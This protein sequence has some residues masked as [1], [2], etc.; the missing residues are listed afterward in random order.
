MICI[1]CAVDDIDPVDETFP[2]VPRSASYV[3]IHSSAGSQLTS[4]VDAQLVGIICDPCLAQ[5]VLLDSI[6][7]VNAW[8]ADGASVAELVMRAEGPAEHVEDTDGGQS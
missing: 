3:T 8:V 1:R 7:E 4:R 2:P 6:F 5:A